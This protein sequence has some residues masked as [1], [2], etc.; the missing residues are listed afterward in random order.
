M[1]KTSHGRRVWLRVLAAGTGL[2]FSFASACTITS[3]D[4]GEEDDG[5]SSGETSS[6]STS[7]GSTS[8]GGGAGGGEEC[9]G[10]GNLWTGVEPD[11]DTLCGVMDDNSCEPGSS[12]E[13][14]DIIVDC[15]CDPASGCID[16]LGEG[17]CAAACDPA[18]E[19]V[20]VD[21]ECEACGN[22]ACV[23]EVEE[24]MAD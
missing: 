23:A 2:A 22:A 15:V 24:C 1:S 4:D 12:C 7:S 17:P 6:G 21:D 8:S 13:L 11:D 14:F 20:I 19:D 10:C 5:A 16:E 3:T 9:S 18:A